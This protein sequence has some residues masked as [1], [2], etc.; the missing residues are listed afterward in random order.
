MLC[1]GG[2]QEGKEKVVDGGT[3]GIHQGRSTEGL[4]MDTENAKLLDDL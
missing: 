4:H 2:S 3:V 1:D